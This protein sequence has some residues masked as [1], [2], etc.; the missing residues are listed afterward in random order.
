MYTGQE[1][2]SISKGTT[3]NNYPEE[4]LPQANQVPAS[5]A[6][7]YSVY[8]PAPSGTP[9]A[10][11]VGYSGPPGNSLAAYSVGQP[12]GGVAP[13]GRGPPGFEQCTVGAWKDDVFNCFTQCVPSFCMGT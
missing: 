4:P 1:Y 10:Y 2:S 5:Q 9:A 13:A 12:A 3:T 6:N 7:P 11:S 8:S